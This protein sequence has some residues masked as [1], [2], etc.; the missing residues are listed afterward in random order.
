[1]RVTLTTSVKTS[2]S[3][4]T[5]CGGI[6][7]TGRRPSTARV[8]ALSPCHG[9]AECALTPRNVTVALRLPRQPAWI[10]LSVGS[11]TIARSA[12]AHGAPWS[13]TLDILGDVGALRVS[14]GALELIS[15]G[16]TQRIELP[17]P[18]G[19]VEELRAFA[20]AIQEGAP[21]RNTPQQAVQD[22]AVI[23][24]M[25]RSAET[26]VRTDVARIV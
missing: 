12:Y 13:T 14:L 20:A 25:L 24:A 5:G 8:I 15:G 9:R 3:I 7:V 6:R 23:E 26:G 2:P 10:A 21:H 18:R 4:S 16:A 1:M 17:A 22:V 19:V 11:S